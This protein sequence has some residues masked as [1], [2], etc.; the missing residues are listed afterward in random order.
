ML[1][2]IGLA[3]N[4]DGLILVLTRILATVCQETGGSLDCMWGV[5]QGLQWTT[6]INTTLPQ[7]P[8]NKN[9]QCCNISNRTQF[10]KVTKWALLFFAGKRK[11]ETVQ[12]DLAVIHGMLATTMN[13]V[14][15]CWRL[16]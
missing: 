5:Q 14:A 7:G 1:A 2:P 4:S 16:P 9:V 6:F 8:H 3:H 13:M 12:C 15:T 11:K 10:T